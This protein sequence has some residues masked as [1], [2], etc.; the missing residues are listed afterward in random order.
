MNIILMLLLVSTLIPGCK[1]GVDPDKKSCI[2]GRGFSGKM[3]LIVR[4]DHIMMPLCAIAM[5]LLLCINIYAQPD[6]ISL[7]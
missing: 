2:I 3:K 1:T 4:Y 5:S 7:M 6:A